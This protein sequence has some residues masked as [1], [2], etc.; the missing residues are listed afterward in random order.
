MGTFKEV[1]RIGAFK[2]SSVLYSWNWVN[3][4]R[5]NCRF[6]MVTVFGNQVYA[7]G[8]S[9][10]LL[11]QSQGFLLEHLKIPLELLELDIFLS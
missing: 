8:I 6:I 4:K 2:E 9:F 7:F 10:E 3:Y 1:R 11:D 5:N